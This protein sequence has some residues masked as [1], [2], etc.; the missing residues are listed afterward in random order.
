MIEYLENWL[1]GIQQNYGVN[2]IIF[3]IIYFASIIPFWFSIYKIIAGLKNR[4]LN[5]VRTF[6]IILGIII[7]LPF[8][9]VALF[10]HNLPFWFW[11]V[12]TCVIGYSTY[13]TIRRIKSAK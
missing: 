4:N 11:I 2:P 9:Y 7:I 8:T 5:Q 12:A 1:N 10:G 13:S 3:A 6:G